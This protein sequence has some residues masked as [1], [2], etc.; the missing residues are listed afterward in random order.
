MEPLPIRPA[1]T[2]LLTRDSERGLEVLLVQRASE[3]AF[4]GGAWVFPGGRVEPSDF[5]SP[6]APPSARFGDAPEL[7]AARLAA[8][9][10]T[11]EEAGLRIDVER[12]VP[13]SHWTTPEGRPRRFA[14]WFFVAE[15]DPGLEV[16]VDGGEIRAHRWQSPAAALALQAAGEIDLPVPTYVSLS[17]LAG[18]QRAA[19]VLALA[20]AEPPFVFV[21]R[22]RVTPD[23]IVSLYHGDLAYEGA[24]LHGEGPRHRLSMLKSGYRYER[25]R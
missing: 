18:Y 15:V 22:P 5:A 11:H 8:V 17:V 6:L 9:R 1:A 3:L 12:L 20:R 13:L 14:T 21:P 24:E 2:V 19:D 23:G 16:V 4:H 25:T 7:H 10:E